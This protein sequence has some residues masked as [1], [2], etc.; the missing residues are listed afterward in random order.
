MQL[1]TD[2]GGHVTTGVEVE[3]IITRGETA[4]G[5]I[6]GGEEI[7]ARRAVIANTTPTQLY[8]R[9]VDE[10]AVP[11]QTLVQ[12][13]RFRYNERAGTQIHVALGE[14]LRWRDSRLD[15]TAIIHLNGGLDR[16]ALA[17][18]QASAGLLPAEPTIVVGQPTVLDPSRAPEG[19]GVVWIQLQQVPYAPRGDAAGMIDVGSGTWDD[20]LVSAFTERV[21]GALE[22]HVENWP[23][24]RRTTVTLPPPE[25]ERRN[26]NLVRGD[27]Y[28]GSCDLAQSYL[29]RPLPGYGAHATPVS[30]LYMCG[31]STFPGQGLSAASGRI[32][33]RQVLAASRPLARALHGRP[34]RDHRHPSAAVTA[35]APRRNDV[36]ATAR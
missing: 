23:A 29:W 15:K 35:G 32:V 24:A 20:N 19:A 28:G 30:R 31:A 7:R 3:R 11:G 6:A 26:I 13:R 25:L 33:A 34:G 16:I 2:S 14:P 17:C 21:L 8:G 10:S 22:R 27:I 4:T 1:I 9:L 18:A 36:P 5:V 12:A